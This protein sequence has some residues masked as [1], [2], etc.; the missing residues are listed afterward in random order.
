MSTGNQQ[1]PHANSDACHW[2]LQ[3]AVSPAVKVLHC[4]HATGNSPVMIHKLQLEEICPIWYDL[5]SPPHIVHCAESSPLPQPQ[6]WSQG[7]HC[8]DVGLC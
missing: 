7:L 2:M 8:D 5:V 6:L 3:A 1:R 4:W